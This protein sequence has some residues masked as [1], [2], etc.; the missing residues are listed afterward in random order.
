MW[1]L[2]KEVCLL[3]SQ[4]LQLG[5]VTSG[6]RCGGGIRHD[7]VGLRAAGFSAGGRDD[8]SG[9][10]GDGE[11]NAWRPLSPD[12]APAQYVRLARLCWDANPC[13]RCASNKYGVDFYDCVNKQCQ[14][15][16]AKILQLARTIGWSVSII[17]LVE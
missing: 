1:E 2:Y 16:V 9:G 14:T 11:E 13:I 4:G 8:S 5:S 6:S 7:G 17:A 12:E 3:D 10:G 15:G